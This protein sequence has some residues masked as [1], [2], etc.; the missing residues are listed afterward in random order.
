MGNRYKDI[1]T[2]I[3]REI[4]RMM[5]VFNTP[6]AYRIEDD[7]FRYNAADYT[8]TTVETG[9]ATETIADAA[10]GV[11]E[12][13]NG[14]A[15][16]DSDELQLVGES[17]ILAAGKPVIFLAKIKVDDAL[18]SDLFIGLSATDTDILGGT[19]NG[20]LFQKDDGDANLDF[21]CRAAAAGSLSDTGVDLADDTWIVV[22][23]EWDGYGKVTPFYSTDVSGKNATE[24]TA[25]IANIPSTEMRISFGV[26]N[27]E[28]VAKTLSL[29]YIRCAGV[30]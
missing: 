17:V 3:K 14:T 5:E 2:D 26:R 8:I 16:D 6:Y 7:F 18:Q 1:D 4:S 27:G 21:G 20:V 28:A 22:G 12:I 10:G 9:S 13:K 11:L 29:D 25:V 15:D 24:L 23:F 30:R 19:D